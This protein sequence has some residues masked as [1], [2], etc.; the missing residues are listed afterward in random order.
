M[1]N[2]S[3]FLVLLELIGGYFG[4]LGLGWILAGDIFKG[5]MILIA[6]S[7][8]LAVGVLLSVA[9]VGCLAAIFGPLHIVIPIISAIK[10]NEYVKY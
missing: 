6:Y 3:G 2:D 4:L 7:T 5:L 9:S 1:R 8:F 10:L